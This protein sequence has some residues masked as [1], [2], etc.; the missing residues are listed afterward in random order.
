[1]GNEIKLASTT[2]SDQ[3]ILAALPEGAHLT[4]ES[5]GTEPEGGARPAQ[6]EAQPERRGQPKS[7]YQ[8]RIDRLV[9]ERSERDAQIEKLHR[10]NEELKRGSRAG[11]AQPAPRETPLNGN[12]NAPAQSAATE[13]QQQA[14][15][16][17][18][19]F[20]AKI[21]AHFASV[22]EEF[23]D[24]RTAA[25]SGAATPINLDPEQGDAARAALF[26]SG[27]SGKLF[28]HM[29]ENP[30]FCEELETL[31]PNAIYSKLMKLSGRLE[32]PH[33][34]G[35]RSNDRIAPAPIRP[36]GG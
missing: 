27:N 22:R 34:N 24:L 10:E 26:D 25:Q 11:E 7:A 4:S 31:S 36:V 12:G 13:T 6:E 23:G 18:P 15:P 8:K 17:P 14:P 28:R 35:A 32:A 3:E 5:E 29:L 33:S 20:R 16:V 30:E 1:M 2:N 21:D 19:E 9:R